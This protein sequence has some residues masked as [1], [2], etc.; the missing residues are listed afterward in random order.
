M[1]IGL[2]QN[3]KYALVVPTSMGI[4]ITPPAGRPVNVGGTFIM[5]ATSAE[6]NVASGL[7]W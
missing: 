1:K 2:K 5:Q 6:S 7:K 4:R 3:G